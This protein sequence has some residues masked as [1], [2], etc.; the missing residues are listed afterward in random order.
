[1]PLIS[2]AWARSRYSKLFFFLCSIKNLNGALTIVPLQLVLHYQAHNQHQDQSCNATDHK[3]D[4]IVVWRRTHR[5]LQRQKTQ[6]TQAVSEEFKHFTTHMLKTMNS[7]FY[8]IL[9]HFQP[10]PKCRIYMLKMKAT[11]RR[12]QGAAYLLDTV[13]SSGEDL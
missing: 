2:H 12:K 8:S 6:Q 13:T 11:V 4:H 7:S 10:W 3:D 1:M 9:F 5:Q